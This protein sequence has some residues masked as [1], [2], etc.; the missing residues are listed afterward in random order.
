MSG[1]HVPVL[2]K[3]VMTA[4]NPR[5]DAIY[6]DGTFGGGGYSEALLSHAQCRVFAIDRDPDAVQRGQSL[7]ERFGGRLTLVHGRFSQMDKLLGAQ[8]LTG[9]DGV[10]L[11]IGVSSFQLDDA[12][13]GFSF[14]SDAPLD[15]R[16]DRSGGQTAA[17]L[18][19]QLTETRLAT[20]LGDFSEEKRARAIARAIVAARPIATARQL[21]ELIERVVPRHG[22]KTHPA[23]R[24][25]QA[26]RIAVND[27]LGELEHGLEA[28]ER[29][30]NPAGR[31]AVVTF[32]SLEDRIVKRF[33]A[34]RLGRKPSA[35]RHLPDRAPQ[36]ALFRSI[37]KLPVMPSAEEIRSNPRARS[38]KLRAAERTHIGAPAPTQTGD[39]I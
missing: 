20:L 4:L 26:L 38:A 27:E 28:A 10:A 1:A 35:S 13:R 6:I 25:F 11:D 7:C 12:A 14:S 22:R 5:D 34:Q 24:T 31:L 32:H 17:D 39:A 8:A 23:T 16:M 2:L 37:G 29:V 15:M 3:E 18:C 30:L 36:P 21:A 9:A 19:N 33:F